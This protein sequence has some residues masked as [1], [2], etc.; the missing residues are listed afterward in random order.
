[1]AKLKSGTRIYG[2][3][4]IDNKLQIT[5]GPVLVGTVSST[6]TASQPLQVTGGTY[7]SGSVGIGTTNPLSASSQLHI[8]N[9]SYHGVSGDALLRLVGVGGATYIQSGIT[10]TSGSSAPIV[11][12]NIFANNEWAR[13]TS[14]GNLLV[15]SAT[16]TGTASQLL[17]VTGGAYVSGNLGVGIINPVSPLEVSQDTTVPIDLTIT[18]LNTGN[19]ITK[20]SRIKFRL[21]DSVGTKKDV[22]YI[23]AYTYNLDSSAGNYLSF[24]TRTAD[25][26]PTEKLRL[27]KDGNLVLGSSFIPTGTASQPLQVTG[28]AYVSG[29]VG[30]GAT[31]PLQKLHVLGNLLVA[32]GSDT[33]QHI[34]QKPYELNSGTLSWEGSAGQ[35]FS[36]TNNLTSGSIF[37]VND[38]SGIPSIDVNATGTISLGAYGGNIGVGI[39]N[40]TSKLE[41]VGIIKDSSGNVR[42]IPQN[43]QS[44][45]YILVIGDVGK[46]ISITT[47][48]VTVNSGIFSAGDV[49]SIYNNSSSSQTITQ[50]TSVTMYLSGSAT[51]GNRTL[52]QRGV[53][54]VLCVAS[55]TFV[56]FGAGLS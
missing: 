1:M 6:G 5:S 15:G 16:S 2:T 8:N 29:S 55:N 28:G 41:V 22:A 21:T 26:N 9:S 46:H 30:I 17:Q 31:N 18:N 52:L 14:S 40:P 25:A 48:G 38:V 39:T 32:A 45:A 3:A 20:A 47:G 27:D 53:C 37:S 13:F 56:I 42:A 51:T 49:V 19:N 34:T 54:T 24:F 7:I 44:A 36:I 23:T 11:F 50:G 4:T 33:T 10:A 12:T 35:L 43:S